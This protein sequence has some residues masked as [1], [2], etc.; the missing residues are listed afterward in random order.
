MCIRD[1]RKPIMNILDSTP[2]TYN[3]PALS[4]LASQAMAEILGQDN[5]LSLSPVM[6]GEDFGL[7]GRTPEKIPLCMFWL[8]AVSPD[9]FKESREQKGKSLPS[10]HSS[11]YAPA[12]E[13]TIKTGVK[14]LTAI[15]VKL[16]NTKSYKLTD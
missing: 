12:P 11:I 6:G 7:Y 10:L 9:K 5:V 14:A 1:R 2:P 16:L 8:G 4:R 3:D 13:L 15:A